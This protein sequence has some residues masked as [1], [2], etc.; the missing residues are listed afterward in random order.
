MVIYAATHESQANGTRDPRWA[1]RLFMSVGMVLCASMS[2]ADEAHQIPFVE[3]L[4]VMRAVVSAS[5]GDYETVNVFS[6]LT[7]ASVK[8]TRS[9]EAPEIPARFERSRFRAPY[10][11][12]I[13]AVP[14]PFVGTFM[15]Q[16]R[17]NF[18]ARRRNFPL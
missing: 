1:W 13:C 14:G 15:K 6:D 9:G 7:A 17:R 10:G 11:G 4:T 5:Q 8:V 3:G 12:G 2:Y 18:P 16:I